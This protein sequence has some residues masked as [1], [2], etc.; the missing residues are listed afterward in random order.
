MT[1]LRTEDGWRQQKI[2][3]FA[4]D[5]FNL[6]H[7]YN[8]QT[9]A[10]SV[11]AAGCAPDATQAPVNQWHYRFGPLQEREQKRQYLTSRADST[12][13]WVYTLLGA[14]GKQLATYNGLQGALCG[15][16]PAP[17]QIWPVEF[18]SYGPSNTRLITRANGRTEYVVSDYLGSTRLLIND[19]GQTLQKLSHRPF[20]ITA[21]SQGS[22]ARTSYIGREHDN[23]SDLG[24]FG[25][26]M[27]EPLYGRF[28]STDV[29]WEKYLPLQPYQYAGN[30][31]IGKSDP[32]GLEWYDIDGKGTWKYHKDS[33]TRFVVRT[34]DEGD[35]VRVV[36]TCIRITAPSLG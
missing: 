17:L 14:D 9:A 30:S 1:T 11:A 10:T 27:Y 7:I 33:P 34:N 36:S 35:E 22:G 8:V 21:T 12:L 31:P 13:A 18:N 6:I 2:E 4:Y 16:T 20:G 32:S 19:E 25:V 26:R 23:E 24:F 29:L 28:L 15:G 5:P 3:S